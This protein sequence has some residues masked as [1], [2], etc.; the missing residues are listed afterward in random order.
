MLKEFESPKTLLEKKSGIF[1]SL[2][3]EAGLA[4]YFN[5]RK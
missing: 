2:A 3:K 1:Y 4:N 5:K